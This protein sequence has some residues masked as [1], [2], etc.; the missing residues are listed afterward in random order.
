MPQIND[1]YAVL[2]VSRGASK[3]E[4]TKAYR[5]LAKKYHPDLNPGDEEAAKKMA[6]VNAAYDSIINGTPYGPRVS[7]S[8]YQRTSSGGQGGYSTSGGYG[9][10]GGGYQGGYTQ[11]GGT[12]YYDPL[13]GTYTYR[14]TTTG[15]QGSRQYYDPFEDMFRGWAEQASQQSQQYQEAQQKARQAYQQTA[16]RTRTQA[17]GCLKW[18]VAMLVLNFFLNLLLGGCNAMRFGM[19]SNVSNAGNSGDSGY[20]Q[21]YDEDESENSSTG[22]S[23]STPAGA[24]NVAYSYSY[25]DS[26]SYS[27]SETN[28]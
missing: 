6:E 8:G 11:Q 15:Q 16:R 23:T 10:P 20:S 22:T 3:E 19:Y 21:Q 27:N 25:N 5:K 24:V 14:R 1:P 17:S 18:I 13:T 2:G 7:S 26:N 28:A 9:T 12:Y 4:V